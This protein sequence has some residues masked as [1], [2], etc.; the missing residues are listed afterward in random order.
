MSGAQ[1]S[2][3]PVLPFAAVGWL[4]A[5][6]R[7]ENPIG[8]ILLVLSLVFLLASDAGEYAVMAYRQGYHLPLAR[9]A[10]FLAGWWIWLALLLPLPVGLFPDGRLSR[11]WRIVLWA[12]VSVCAGL[13]GILT[14]RDA[15][16]IGARR[17]RIDS[18]GELASVG[19]SSG[20][21]GPLYGVF[22]AFCLVWALRPLVGFR[23]S[24]GEARQQL[25]WLIAGGIVCLG[26]LVLTLAGLSFAF[27]SIIA[28]PIGMGV[29]ILKYRLYDIDRLISRT[30]S[31]TILTAMLAAVFVGIVV[32]ATD[33]LPFSSPVA[34][35]AS[36]LAAAALFN[37][38]RLRVQRLVD[39]RFNRA[40]Y[41]AE[42]V[43][44]AFSA[45]LREAV[46]LGIV[47]CELVA[48]V[49]QAVQPA[50][51]TLWIRPSGLSHG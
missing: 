19:G 13:V 43:V 1:S 45:R 6:R 39:R 8:W 24:R 9:T 49:E 11:R 51:A 42:A 35:A 4:V 44:A 29:G 2:G 46:D 33:V 18:T 27:V 28:L 40:R 47:R 17:I 16:G 5:R 20:A 22:I 32:F 31:Y 41:D 3:L 34:V 37:P 25:K 36:T 12:Y 14:W 10:V 38:L 21:A 15:I 48:A 50:H 30:V 7:S 26:G 23:R